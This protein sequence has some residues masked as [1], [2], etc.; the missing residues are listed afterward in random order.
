M[1]SDLDN[2]F[3]GRVPS[4][5]VLYCSWTPPNQILQFQEHLPAGISIYTFSKRCKKTQQWIM[6]PQP[7]EYVVVIPTKY[8]DPHG[9]AYC[10]DRFIWVVKQTDTMYIVP[11]EA[12]VGP[13]H[14]V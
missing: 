6:R 10:V 5:T 8:K 9:W 4:I 3:R 12:I 2:I 13:A 11:V 14:L 1:D 7:E